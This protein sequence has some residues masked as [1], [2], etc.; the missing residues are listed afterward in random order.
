MGFQRVHQK[1]SH[2]VYEHQDGRRTTIPFHKGRD[3][4]R[5]LVADIIKHDLEI[6]H[7]EF[8]SYLR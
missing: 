6:T 8:L 2:R 7:E 4:P 1:G 5:G 3:L